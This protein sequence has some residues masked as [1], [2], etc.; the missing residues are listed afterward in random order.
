MKNNRFEWDD[1]KALANL[2]KHG[3]SF[4]FATAVFDDAFAV[5][6]DD[7]RFDYGEIRALVIGLSGDV[8][9]A[10]TYTMRDDRF[11]IITARRATA[12]E[13]RHYGNE[14]E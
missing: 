4:E 3:V 7:D 6:F 11:R 9:I 12:S 2:A 10:V 8:L 14:R 13:A 1:V 5:D